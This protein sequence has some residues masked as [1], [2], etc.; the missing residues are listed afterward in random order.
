[1]P[2]H[3][4]PE[5]WEEFRSEFEAGRCRLLLSK[6]TRQWAKQRRWKLKIFRSFDSQF[7]RRL[8]TDQDAFWEAYRDNAFHLHLREPSIVVPSR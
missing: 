7:V 4:E 3:W 8:L 1:M 5:S 2:T 6:R